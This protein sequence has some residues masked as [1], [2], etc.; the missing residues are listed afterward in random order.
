MTV[1]EVKNIMLGNMYAVT[2]NGDKQDLIRFIVNN[3]VLDIK[4]F[5]SLS[6]KSLIEEVE[7]NCQVVCYDMERSVKY[8]MEYLIVLLGY[9]VDIDDPY[10]FFDWQIINGIRVENDLLLIELEDDVFYDWTVR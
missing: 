6:I 7:N 3:F 4:D 1:K 9:D 10:E 8:I 5:D 2:Y